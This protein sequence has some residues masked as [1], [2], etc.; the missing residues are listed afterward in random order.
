[1]TSSASLYDLLFGP[2][3]KEYCLY[4]YLLT[5]WFLVSAISSACMAVFVALFYKQTQPSKEKPAMPKMALL[6]AL[7]YVGLMNSAAYLQS[8]LL[9]NMCAH[10]EDSAKV[11]GPALPNPSRIGM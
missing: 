10:S 1:M 5:L 4:F 3:D 11:H 7:T 6:A 9:Y 8:R 2:L